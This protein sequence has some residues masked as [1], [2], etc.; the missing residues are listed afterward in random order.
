MLRFIVRRWGSMLTRV[1]ISALRN[2]TRGTWLHTRA[3]PTRRNA[4]TLTYLLSTVNVRE[5]VV[6]GILPT[7]GIP[8][9]LGASRE[10]RCETVAP[11]SLLSQ[12]G[13]W[14]G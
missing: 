2:S 5:G 4:A 11:C 8:G 6:E 1:P 10:S 7:Q 3:S 12:P 9:Y 14:E 13:L